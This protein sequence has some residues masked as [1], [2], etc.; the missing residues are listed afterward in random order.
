MHAR[1]Q[2]RFPGAGVIHSF[3]PSERPSLV[4]QTNGAL[5]CWPDAALLHGLRRV[6]QR[7]LGGGLFVLWPATSFALVA[8]RLAFEAALL[9]RLAASPI[10]GAA[11]HAFLAAAEF[12]VGHTASA[13]RLAAS[14]LLLTAVGRS[15][16]LAGGVFR[17]FHIGHLGQSP[18]G[19]DEKQ[20]S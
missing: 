20:R 11:L 4:E 10:L 1:A 5:T 13:L 6:G 3:F 19:A 7:R 2:K 12:G 17:R 16:C 15:V 8:A 18:N 9:N 14:Q